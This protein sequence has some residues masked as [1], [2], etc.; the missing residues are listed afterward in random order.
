[1]ALSGGAVNMATVTI[2][3][4]AVDG[5][6]TDRLATALASAGIAVTEA[7]R[8]RVTLIAW[9]PAL[10]I[11]QPQWSHLLQARR[12]GRLLQVIL[13]P[14]APPA[15][16]ARDR[17]LDLSAWRGGAG[18]AG[19][20]RIVTAINALGSRQA[21]PDGV[22]HHS[23]RA[24]LVGYVRIVAAAASVAAAPVGFLAN[25]GGA[26]DFICSLSALNGACQAVGLAKA[27]PGDAPS[28]P[29]SVKRSLEGEWGTKGCRRKGRFRIVGGRLL[30]DWGDFRSEAEIEAIGDRLVV[31]ADVKTGA[32][33]SLNVV[34][35]TLVVREVNT[36]TGTSLVRCGRGPWP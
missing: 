18:N 7:S 5:D 21:L 16:F 25:V 26:R 29:A 12:R 30:Q 32:R 22:G 24:R 34:G 4:A 9:S 28:T 19:L 23:S 8:E 33:V 14:C 1:M 31:V 2:V 35:H 15:P 3:S 13:K 20:N 11:E 27:A 6:L 17:P 36:T 10:I